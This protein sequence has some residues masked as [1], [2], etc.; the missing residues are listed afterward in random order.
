MCASPLLPVSSRA[1]PEL[2]SARLCNG[3]RLDFGAHRGAPSE[4]M[5]TAGCS[6]A[7]KLQD[8]AAHRLHALRFT[9]Q[10]CLAFEASLSDIARPNHR[11]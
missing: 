4:C 11:T 9:T 10:E 8:R 1:V 2:G 6:F 7:R 5:A 3:L